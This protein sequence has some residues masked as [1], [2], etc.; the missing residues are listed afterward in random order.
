[1]FDCIYQN[2]EELSS[3]FE[4]FAK[5]GKLDYVS[6]VDVIERYDLGLSKSQVMDLMKLLDEDKDGVIDYKEFIGRLEVDYNLFKHEKATEEEKE[7]IQQLQDFGK[8]MKKEGLNVNLIH[9]YN[10]NIGSA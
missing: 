5:N 10:L 1:M 3:Q 2:Q 9:R 6:F 7:M 4:K 8:K